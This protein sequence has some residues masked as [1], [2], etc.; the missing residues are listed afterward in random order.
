MLA[1]KI[2]GTMNI[3]AQTNEDTKK[4]ILQVMRDATGNGERNSEEVLKIKAFMPFRESFIDFMKPLGTEEQFD[5]YL[6]DVQEHYDA[7]LRAKLGEEAFLEAKE[8]PNGYCR[9]LI[10]E[11]YALRPDCFLGVNEQDTLIGAVLNAFAA[12]L[13]DT[14]KM[15]E[16]GFS[17]QWTA[18]FKPILGDEA[19]NRLQ[20]GLSDIADGKRAGR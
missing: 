18:I 11:Y 6:G 16:N 20:K 8:D 17:L 9:K 3:V 10:A 4:A 2:G 13:Y 19:Y 15:Q 7:N 12:G 5:E 14:S 1:A